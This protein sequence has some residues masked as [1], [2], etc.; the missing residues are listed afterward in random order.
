MGKDMVIAYDNDMLYPFWFYLRDYTNLKYFADKPTRDIRN[1]VVI[2][3][4][5]DNFAKVDSIVGNDYYKFD[6]MRLW[7]PMEDYKNLNWSRI[8]GALTNPQLR[9]GIFDIWLN[10][11]YRTYATAT[12]N[13]SLTLENWSPSNRMRLYIRKDVVS[14]MWTYGA[15]PAAKPIVVDPYAQ[16]SIQL[17]PTQVIT[18]DQLQSPRQVAV[19]P[20]GSLYVANSANNRVVHFSADGQMLQAW[21][22][23]ADISKGAAP[24][25]TFNQI[26]GIAVGPDGSVYVSDWWNHRIQKF[27]ADGQFIKMWGHLGDGTD[28]TTFYGPRGLAVDAKGRVYVADTGNKYIEIYDAD[29]NYITRFGGAGSD[30][31]Q[32]DEPVGVALDKQGQVYVTDTWNQ[33]VQVFKPDATGMTYTPVL[34]WNIDGWNG[35]SVENKPYI[36]VDDQHVFVT[37]PEGYRVIEFTL[38]GDFVHVWGSYSADQ[39]GFGMTSGIAIDAQGAVWVSD[40]AN[41]KILK[42]IVP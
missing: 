10:A 20:D 5:Q 37:D 23:F 31:G 1:A 33:R 4:G 17:A 30:P 41:Q 15:A 36:A 24:G 3:A 19:A 34:E 11:D 27:T 35:Q 8:V 2:V 13:N 16:G 14:E 40:S 22:S 18:S 26:W 42:F 7:W 38:K 6:Y 21:G 25:G 39:T 9:A 29:G 32:L 28:P 12:N